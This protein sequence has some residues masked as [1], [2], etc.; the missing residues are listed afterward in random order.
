MAV[1]TSPLATLITAKGTSTFII[2]LFTQ[3]ALGLMETSQKYLGRFVHFVKKIGDRLSVPEGM[4]R[5]RI[6]LS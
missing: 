5:P 4:F 6:V 1:T 2:T 3:F